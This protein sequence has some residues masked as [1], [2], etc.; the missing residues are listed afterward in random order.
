MNVEILKLLAPYASLVMALLCTLAAY[1]FDAEEDPE[2]TTNFR[3]PRN[4]GAAPKSI[5]T[6]KPSRRASL[7]FYIGGILS[8]AFTPYLFVL[9]R[10]GVTAPLSESF[11]VW[12][13][14]VIFGVLYFLLV[15]MFLASRQTRRRKERRENAEF[16]F[17][18]I[19]AAVLVL[20]IAFAMHAASTALDS[21]SKN[22]ENNRT[23]ARAQ[24][25]TADNN[26][27]E[28]ERNEAGGKLSSIYAN[29]KPECRTKEEAR[30]YIT[31]MLEIVTRDEKLLKSRT[32]AELYENVFGLKSFGWPEQPERKDIADLRRM[33]LHCT[34]ILNMLHA[35]FDDVPHIM[36][37]SEYDTCPA[38]FNDIRP[39]PPLLT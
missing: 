28:T 1:V 32:A 21:L 35:G 4:F 36:D 39:H 17:K 16:A 31:T 25:Y 24:L 15:G 10:P 12:G 8:C 2:Q 38:Y 26:I 3:F 23:A 18:T 7:I 13:G 27:T 9:W 30:A 34:Y 37:K 14:G 20:G 22:A 33:I 29:P 11:V 6:E 5:D 19:E